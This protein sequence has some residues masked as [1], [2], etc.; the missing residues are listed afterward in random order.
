MHPAFASIEFGPFSSDYHVAG[1]NTEFKSALSDFLERE[2][3]PQVEGPFRSTKG[4]LKAVYGEQKHCGPN[5]LVR[6]IYELEFSFFRSTGEDKLKIELVFS[7]V[8]GTFSVRRNL[9]LF[10]WTQARRNLHVE[11]SARI[12][13]TCIRIAKGEISEAICPL[14]SSH[15]TVHDSPDLFD[16]RCSKGCFNYNYHRDPVDGQFLHGHF[17]RKPST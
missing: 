6:D 1:V 8:T 5:S 16:V 11:E 17:F 10:L 2:M 13:A 14:C 3:L 4:T 9:P 15:L 7:P 12:Q